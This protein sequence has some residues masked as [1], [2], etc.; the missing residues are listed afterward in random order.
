[1]LLRMM[2]VKE[3][4]IESCILCSQIAL[5]LPVDGSEINSLS[6]VRLNFN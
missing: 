3:A 6:F 2:I 5:I 1:M 4:L